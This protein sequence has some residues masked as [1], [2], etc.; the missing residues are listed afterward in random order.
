MFSRFFIDRPI[1]ASVLSI[2]I[3]LAG[4]ITLF[5]LSVAQYPEITPP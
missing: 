4:G 5:T 2:I 1:F 3:T